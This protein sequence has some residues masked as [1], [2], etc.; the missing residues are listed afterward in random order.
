MAYEA[1][2]TSYYL[3]PGNG[4]PSYLDSEFDAYTAPP[5]AV[6]N[7]RR[8]FDLYYTSSS[9]MLCWQGTAVCTCTIE[10]LVYVNDQS[11]VL[12][13]SELFGLAILEILRGS[14]T[15]S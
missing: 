8:V 14:Y 12:I 15:D 2:W 11:N 9:S 3:F 6:S 13:S 5:S 4:S 10:G 7:P 1:E